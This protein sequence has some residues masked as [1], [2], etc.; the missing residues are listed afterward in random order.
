[1]NTFDLIG[2][3]PTCAS[4]LIWFAIVGHSTHAIRIPCTIFRCGCVCGCVLLLSNDC[5]GKL[6]LA[7][8]VYQGRYKCEVEP[9]KTYVRSTYISFSLT[10]DVSAFFFNETSSDTAIVRTVGSSS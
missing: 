5:Q 2:I 1:M 9:K 6:S 8:D 3:P 10:K 4:A 7:F